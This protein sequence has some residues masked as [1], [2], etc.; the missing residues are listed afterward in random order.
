[1][2]EDKVI[3]KDR[4]K[5]YEWRIPGNWWKHFVQNMLKEN[6]PRLSSE[7]L[8]KAWEKDVLSRV[9]AQGSLELTPNFRFVACPCQN[10]KAVCGVFNCRINGTTEH[11]CTGPFTQKKKR[12]LTQIASLES[13]DKKWTDF[14]PPEW[15]CPYS[16]VEKQSVSGKQEAFDFILDS[17]EE[18]SD[19][20]TERWH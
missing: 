16:L 12:S 14:Q 17:L 3:P 8:Q 19:Y 6:C 7:L 11:L 15:S 10:K 1:M 9:T 5:I 20:K 13:P 4:S 2:N 18:R